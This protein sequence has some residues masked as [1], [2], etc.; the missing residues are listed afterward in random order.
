[1]LNSFPILSSSYMKK[2]YFLLFFLLAAGPLLSAESPFVTVQ[3]HQF[4]LNAKPYYYIGTNY[5]YGSYL[6]LEKDKK[7]GLERLQKELNFLKEKGVTN[8]R[9]LTAVEGSGQ[10]NG[11]QRV[12]PPYQTEKGKFNEQALDGLDVLLYEMGKRDM[13]AILFLSN[14]WEWS[15]GFLQYLNWN[16]LIADSVL[17]R[18]LNWD[19]LRDYV[20]K[21]YSCTGCMEGYNKQVQS[22][23]G[24]TNKYTKKKYTEDAT[25][26]AWE[27]A[28]EP[29]PM[30]SAANDAYKTW[31]S[32]TAAFIK[33]LDKN[34]LVTLGHE[35]NMATDGNME[36]Y[37]QIHA[38]KNVDY[39]TIHIWPKNWGWFKEETLDKDYPTVSAN[40]IDYLTKHAA[41][42]KKLGK[43]LVLE[44]FGLPRDHHSFDVTTSTSLRDSYYKTIFGL[45]KKD[46]ETQDVLAGINFWAFGGTA[47][48]VKGQVFWKDGDDYMGDPPME[49]QG[50]NSVFDSDA[51]TWNIITSYTKNS[52]AANRSNNDL[53]A[54]KKATKETVHLYHNLKK[55]VN[56]GI[57]FGHQDA[58]AY[59]VGWKY[60]PGKSDVKE[61]VGDYPAVYGWELGNLELGL[62]YNLDTVPFAKMKEFIQQG[63]ER[64]GV[65]TISWHNANPVTGKNAWDTT[66]GGVAA[67][68]PGGSKHD[69]YKTWLDK[70]AAFMLSLKGK[71]GEAIPILFRPYHELTGNWFWWTKNTCTPEEFKSLWRYTAD[72]LQNKNVHNLLYVY[73]TAD[74]K[75][76]EDFLER[77]PGDDYADMVSFDAYQR[78]NPATD[79]SFVNDV[80]RRL[81]IVE[82]VAKE[83]GK[84]AALA[85]A[86]Y[87]RVPYAEWWTNTLWKAVG[88]RKISY[89]LLWR[90]A[91]LMPNGN[92]HYYVPKK[93]DVSEQ[94]FKK[95]Y[96]LEKTLFE[97]EVAK[98]K[99]YQP[100]K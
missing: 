3:Q 34:H 50:L 76:K 72:Y 25:I 56:K 59:G 23:V 96:S 45:W 100:N 11:V 90:N 14:N 53:P 31:I 41:V 39:L 19:E 13:K 85:E 48:P 20:S 87:E 5:W 24:R 29:R 99:L 81:G 21:F 98:E 66:H 9:V 43:P 33:S 77:Y 1:M 68:L 52:N 73:N 65:V 64:G 83:K 58:L 97:K 93:G 6:G 54:D 42:A 12:K 71:N 35:G 89:V 44:E 57:M 62:A 51:S 4:M 78:G 32:K 28:N 94:D 75:T 69:L 7:K 86:G 80:N 92:W 95:F 55:L 37:E 47:R 8:L 82:E 49:E 16:G 36:L 79:N 30:R 18:K 2:S 26:M 74:F 22:I 91:G 17:R 46:K 10:I 60:V 61:I 40:T 88:D 38:D 70:L 15:G 67:V 84:L 27:L 63:Y